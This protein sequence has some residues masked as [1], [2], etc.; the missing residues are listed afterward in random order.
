MPQIQFWYKDY[1]A[2]LQAIASFFGYAREE[3][4]DIVQQFFLDLLQ[5]KINIQEIQNP[6]A[7]L[8]TAFKRKL[9]DLNRI[10]KRKGNIQELETWHIPS[11]QEIMEKLETDKEL[12]DRIAEAYKKLPARFRRVIYMKYYQGYST[13]KIVSI[14]GYTYQTVYNNLSKGIARLRENLKGG[15]Q[16]LFK[17][18]NYLLSFI[19]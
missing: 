3:A 15:E 7:Y 8:I 17:I 5:K 9:I 2:K 18:I 1:K 6:E 16:A 11:T 14:T 10:S 19:F 12:V 13:E 4:E